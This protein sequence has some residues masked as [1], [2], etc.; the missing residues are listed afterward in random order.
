MQEEGDGARGRVRGAFA[1]LGVEQ[2]ARLRDA[3][4]QGM[5]DAGVV[6]PIVRRSRP[7]PFDCDRQRIEVHRQ[8]AD[9]VAPASDAV[10]ARGDL[11]EGAP[12]N[13]AIAAAA[14]L[15]T[16]R[17]SV[18]W[19]ASPSGTSDLV[20]GPLGGRSHRQRP[21]PAAVR[22]RQTQHRIVAQ[23]IGVVVVA[24][25]LPEQQ[26]RGAQQLRQRVRDQC[27]L[28]AV[29]QLGR[30][31]L[32]DPEPFHHLPQHH[33]AGVCGQSLRLRLSRNDWLNSARKSE[34]FASPIPRLLTVYCESSQTRV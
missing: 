29:D 9:A 20:A 18:G 24:P 10:P 28:P 15:P 2:V 5:V 8:V 13:L 11:Q 19:D 31:P 1:Q 30:H 14:S 16:S 27:Q 32:D 23:P 12:H 25:P 6:V 26:E 3:G 22:H 21:H 34:R 33:R 4:D 17:D 7:T